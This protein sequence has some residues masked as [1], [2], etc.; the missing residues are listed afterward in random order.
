VPGGKQADRR[1]RLSG[2]LRCN[3]LA[4]DCKAKKNIMPK[5]LVEELKDGL[6]VPIEGNFRQSAGA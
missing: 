4:Q 1:S 5:Q 6:L 3:S 2:A